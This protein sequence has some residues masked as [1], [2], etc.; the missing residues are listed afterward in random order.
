MYMAQHP[1][2]QSLS[3]GIG[4]ISNALVHVMV[5]EEEK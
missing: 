3:Y 5:L 2:T 1:K 4:F